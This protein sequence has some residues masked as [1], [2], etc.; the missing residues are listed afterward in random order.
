MVR[1]IKKE[2]AL[3]L[4]FLLVVGAMPFLSYGQGLD[5]QAAAGD[6][7]TL[8]TDNTPN[9][10]TAGEIIETA[11]QTD[12]GEDAV[13]AVNIDIQASDYTNVKDVQKIITDTVKDINEDG[14]K[15]TIDPDKL[16]TVLDE[17]QD[18]VEE[19]KT[20]R[21][22]VK[23]KHDGEE[24]FKDK[25]GDEIRDS[26]AIENLIPE[27]Y[28]NA[29][30]NNA[31]G[32]STS[33]AAEYIE[34]TASGI[35]SN[36]D[37]N[38]TEL[39]ILNNKVNPSEFVRTLKDN[40]ADKSIEYI[41]PDFKMNLQGLEDQSLTGNGEQLTTGSAILDETITD[42]YITQEETTKPAIIVI[43]A[44]EVNTGNVIIAVM[45][46]GLD[47]T[48]PALAQ[49]IYANPREIAGN[50]ID[51][52]GNGYIDDVNG[53][54]F[55][56]DTGTVYDESL[57]LEQAHATHIAGIIAG[58]SNAGDSLAPDAHISIL[59]L[60]VFKNG[61]AYTSDII[62]A[63]EYAD[64]MGAR[65]I[66]C[67]F[68]CAYDNQALKEAMEES[69]ALFVTAAGNARA[70]LDETPVYPAA[71]DLP[72][73]LSVTSINRDGGLSYFSDYG[74]KTV[75]LAAL[76]RDIE[77][78]LPSGKRGLYSG[79]SMSAGI[80]S[81]AAGRIFAANTDLSANE[82]K[83]RLLR[84]ADKISSLQGKVKD[85]ARLNFAEALEG[86]T[87]TDIEN[88][89]FQD[90]FTISDFDSISDAYTLFSAS[91]AV[92]A[93]AGYEHSLALDADGTV[94]SWGD[95]S[96]GQCG[97]GRTSETETLVKVTGL[98]DI[99]QISTTGY[100][101]LALK[102]DGTVWAWGSN[103][104]GQ[105]GDGTTADRLVP[106]QV[107]G[108][109]GIKAISA[110]F[111][112]SMA[113]Q[114]DGTVWV[115]GS[116]FLGEL[117]DG[118]DV[119]KTTPVPAGIT[120]VKSITAGFYVSFAIK[121]DGSV[122]AWG[123][124]G[125]GQ[126]GD[127][128]TVLKEVPVDIGLTDVESIA[129]GESHCLALK[130]DG[131]IW[132]WGNNSFG[133]LGDGTKISRTTPVPVNNVTDITE[134]SAGTDFSSALKSDGTV[135][136]WG[137]NFIGQLGDGS[138][139]DR[140]A[141][142]S[143][144]GVTE[145][146]EL[147]S[148]YFFNL[149]VKTD[150]TIWGW[151]NNHRGQIV[152]SKL[153]L[154]K[155]TE[156]LRL[157]EY[158]QLEI[159][160]HST[161]GLKADGTVWSW[162]SDD[163]GQL[164][165]VIKVDE[166][167]PTQ[168]P[169]LTDITKISTRGYHSLALKADGTV[170]S[171]GLNIYGQV[172]DGTTLGRYLPVR[173]DGLTDVKEIATGENNSYAVKRDGTVWAWG[174]NNNGQLGDGT[175]SDRTTP[176]QV[177]GIADVKEVAVGEKY[178]FAL[179]N[180]GTVWSWG[181]TLGDLDIVSLTN[182]LGSVPGLTDI[183]AISV[184]YSHA[185]ALKADGTV[186]AFGDND[187]G[188]CGNG[189]ST[190]S[191]NT[192]VQ[193][194][195][196]TEVKQ[197]STDEDSSFAVKN[198]G[199][200]WAWGSNSCRELGDGTRIDRNTPI[201]LSGISGARQITVGNLNP[202]YIV[203]ANGI[204]YC[205]G[206]NYRGEL[207]FP[208]IAYTAVPIQ[209]GVSLADDHGDIYDAA[210]Q[211]DFTGGDMKLSGVLNSYFDVDVFAFTADQTAGYSAT[212]T[213][214]AEN[215]IAI[216][217][218]GNKTK[219]CEI[220]SG[221]RI[222][223]EQGQTY[224]IDIQYRGSK[225]DFSEIPYSLE[226]GKAITALFYPADGSIGV[227][228]DIPNIQ[229]NFGKTVSGTDGKKITISD[230]TADYIY[231]VHAGDGTVSG[232]G[233]NCV[234]AI[235][236]AGFTDAAGHALS[237]REYTRY[238]VIIPAG[239]YI[240]SAGNGN[241]ASTGSF[242]TD[243]SLTYS[244]NTDDPTSCTITGYSGNAAVIA[245]PEKI[246]G[247]TVRAIGAKAFYKNAAITELTLPESL[248]SIGSDAFSS[249]TSL[250][251]VN[252]PA[253]VTTIDARVFYSCSNLVS[254][255][256]LS[257]V[258]SIGYGA[259]CDCKLLTNIPLTEKVTSIG[260][261]AFSGC[262][263]LSSVVLSPDLKSLGTYAFKDCDG[264]SAITIPPGI[265]TVKNRAFAYCDN[266]TSVTIP[267][268]ATLIDYAAFYSCPKLSSVYFKGNKPSFGNFAFSGCAGS[269]TLYYYG[270]KT[271]WTSSVTAKHNGSDGVYYVRGLN[272]LAVEGSTGSALVIDGSSYFDPAGGYAIEGSNVTFTVK[273]GFNI[274]GLSYIS[275][276]NT[277]NLALA[278]RS[279]TM[280]GANTTLKA[281][282]T[283][284][285]SLTVCA[286]AGELSTNNTKPAWN[287][288]TSDGAITTGRYRYQMDGTAD[289]GWTV[290]TDTTYT[291]A[292]A[293][294]DNIHTLY[295]QEEYSDG[296]WSE[297]RSAGITID[298]SIVSAALFY[299]ADGSTGVPTSMAGIILSFGKTV[300]GVGGKKVTISD[301]K[302]DC[303][304]I[305]Q[306]NDGTISGTGANCRV[307]I[308]VSQFADNM[309]NILVLKE[310]T[311]YTV[312]IPAG[313]YVDP[314]KNGNQE[315]VGRFTTTCPYS[316]TINTD[317]TTSCT[318][319]GYSGN[320]AVI[321][322]PEKISGYTVRA[323]GTKAFYKNAVITELTLPDSLKLIGADAFDGCT[324]LASVNIPAG[325][326]TIDTRAFFSCSNLVSVN[327]FSGVTSIGYGAFYNCKLL[328]N[329]S[330]TEKVTSI[331][332]YAFNGCN[333]ISNVVLSPLL[334]SLGNY[335]FTDCDG[336]TAITIPPGI[337]TVKNRAFA[338][339][340][341]L[342]SVTIPSNVTLIDYAAFYSCPNLSAVYFKGNKPSFGNLAF[343]GCAGS[344]TLY[345]YGGKTG[346]T[347]S[348][349]AKH[350]GSDGMYY[351]KGLNTLTVE[352]ST[353]GALTI[354]AGCY[355]DPAN[356]YV[357]E[358]STVN[359]AVK[360]GYI[361]TNLSYVSG[362]VKTNL[363]P[364]SRSFIMPAANTTLSAE[365]TRVLSLAVSAES[366]S[367]STNNPKPTWSWT[368]NPTDGITGR[369]RYQID[370]IT[371]NGWTITT[372][373]SYSP[374]SPLSNGLHTLY[375]Q[376]EYIDGAW[377]ES[378]NAGITIDTSIVSA[379]LFYP[380]D[381]STGVPTSMSSIILS[382]GKTVTGVSG[383]EITISDGKTD[384]QYIVQVNDGTISGTGTNCRVTIPVSRF[385]DNMGNIL[386]LKESTEYTVTIP[387][388]AYVDPDQNSNQKSIGRFA[389]TCPYSYTINT[390]DTT[391]CTITGY[392]GNAA[393]IAVPEKNLRLHGESN[394]NKS[395]L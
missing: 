251:A 135:V 143:V 188:Q 349:T 247:Y 35:H 93:E 171:W 31:G 351:V 182:R 193:V 47:I 327:G 324:S 326:T 271:G 322:V 262:N 81:A 14:S 166:S 111:T 142:V 173:V 165:T 158:T 274:T 212:I 189:G 281:V 29:A 206:Q 63:I 23:Y 377:S 311:Q 131:T 132:A 122:W 205:Y 164:G 358:G 12:T 155:P 179:K 137:F 341:N 191:E 371:E 204:C 70:D 244:V 258:T 215:V 92:K 323:I 168:L 130:K 38:D 73:N 279:F 209:C 276:A 211:N 59:P 299:P 375:V 269:L 391:S 114:T 186:W 43:P 203:E 144:S 259:F 150:G 65:V 285:L 175:Q 229:L 134:V 362:T 353:G 86:K 207:N 113:L 103:C 356:R 368:T 124:N 82:M 120:N 296:I 77:S 85:A 126:L 153:Y 365:C 219:I 183:K 169:G 48:H 196:L 384:C 240:D 76:G 245:V 8:M 101:S 253:G 379:A 248:K 108:L 21:F 37:V 336:I 287:W 340:D 230:G 156:T 298:T 222:D 127:G 192:P 312:T 41:Q 89:A 11:A 289:S 265:T 283:R 364:D 330:L 213:N 325:V 390:D 58:V 395:I 84:G 54:N 292:T 237:L 107:G 138:T 357:A 24:A 185:L 263:R 374:A 25:V 252:I 27:N 282:Y 220:K 160:F 337:T 224:Y 310:N 366:G 369:Y 44:D 16:D 87:Q 94:W 314:S 51:D 367:I 2:I 147:S 7:F 121:A 217:H 55:A 49:Y 216:L 318:I 159:G 40:N 78:T 233:I 242:T 306:R 110:G 72:N 50:G 288:T 45:D 231:T 378:K 167:E 383:K 345:Y 202:C 275:G 361:V 295:V 355:F 161:F 315:S 338:Y 75:A 118:T 321:A 9:L 104:Y 348:V 291:P 301:G 218:D 235:P 261:Y 95:N 304:Y 109:C 249:C 62:A 254:V 163:S 20:D 382:F 339:C 99:K 370:G 115:W 246:S 6:P 221:T 199:T 354:D 97:I 297:S 241:A 80:V 309:G 313:A 223:L 200:V 151:G 36:Q 57:G 373:M 372:G 347:S 152:E 141:P 176:V 360:P 172:G 270:D 46:T 344:L 67:S 33:S 198:D 300:T 342:T 394:R 64:K 187:Y 117:G 145:I 69:S 139:T 385:A 116:N 34:T 1:K 239:T 210:T 17:Q 79:T 133:E 335:A 30:G 98:S 96:A 386:V 331:G 60:K 178:V 302:T 106:V 236:V 140:T 227:S 66:N 146:K 10:M 83:E 343:S 320:A 389:T 149:A 32:A 381:G 18:L 136:S 56:D 250:A 91:K 243:Y 346:W 195:G 88:I 388:G 334:Q 328:T 352:G 125:C 190:E 376:E 260:D 100:F 257:G 264:I 363:N 194:S 333:R 154:D 234:V 228:T 112:H 39:I 15:I 387:A 90:D 294:S 286:E 303:Q 393:V 232:G 277:T 307:T 61:T 266:L 105:L 4:T 197:I 71:F 174:A 53:W 170:W 157:N 184:G 267:S 226:I 284:V 52:D 201:Q 392:S 290:T 268:N 22:I 293:L 42:E 225:A 308:P 128:T 119:S 26:V 123:N 129:A 380:A 177:I 180:D 3:I 148:R 238:T 181:A 280:P 332:D 13:K 214:S 5:S 102:T 273:P 319:T 278:S 329:I 68:G 316:Y 28:T 255:S 317:D 162:G 208:Y 305:V 272:T 256:G 74:E 359:F 19:S 350:N